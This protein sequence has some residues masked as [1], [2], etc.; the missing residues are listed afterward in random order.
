MIALNQR[1]VNLKEELDDWETIKKEAADLKDL[2]ELND[3]E[4][5]K[6]I[7]EAQKSLLD[8]LNQKE[9]EVFLSG[10]YDKD[11][12]ILTIMSGA[13]GQDAEDWAAILLR[14]YKRYCERKDFGFKVLSQSFGE[15]GPE[16]RIGIKE[17]SLEIKGKFTYGLLKRE[18]GVHRLVRLSPFSAKKLRHTSFALV[19]IM[20]EIE[21]KGE[22]EI[23]DEDLKVN[24]Y[25]ASGPGGQYV[26]KRDSAVRIT[27][28]PTKIVVSCQ[29][30]R[31]QGLN[32]KKAL[33]ML[34]SKLLKLKQEKEKKEKKKLKGEEI[35]VEWGNQ[36]RSYIFYPY[37]LVKDHRTKVEISNLDEVLDGNLDDFINK[38]LEL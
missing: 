14:M 4:I 28:L 29:A 11:N 27:H 9:I 30:E 10:K 8:K 17:V 33:E 12:A 25:R 18:S 15:P 37:K 23:K 6:G 1:F 19:E 5:E 7:Y 36:I 32:R 38:E 22:I 34:K 24:T 20:P 26:N 16:G 3:Q 31:T 35:N 13:G 21:E 2:I